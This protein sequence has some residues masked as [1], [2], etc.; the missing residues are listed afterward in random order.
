MR[1][2]LDTSYLYNLMDAAGQLSDAE[3]LIL[4]NPDVTIFVSAAS[5]WEMKLKFAARHPS[6]E[7]KSALDPKTVIRLLEDQDVTF[8][9]IMVAHASAELE[10]AIA[11]KDPFDEMLLTQ[12]QSEGLRL[13]TV[14]RNLTGHPLAM[15]P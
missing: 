10:T 1:I 9:P 4:S 2:L 5:I 12:A 15:A 3:R 11:H 13:L 6:G 7:R 8:L 14:D